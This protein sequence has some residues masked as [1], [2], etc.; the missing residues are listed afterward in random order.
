MLRQ[1]SLINIF[2]N[3]SAAITFFPSFIHAAIECSVA[4][5]RIEVNIKLIKKYLDQD[6][7]NIET[8]QNLNDRTNDIVIENGNFSWGVEKIEE[9]ENQDSTKNTK[10]KNHEKG[11]QVINP[12]E[13]LISFKDNLTNQ[14]HIEIDSKKSKNFKRILKNVNFKARKGELIAVI[15]EIGSGKSSLLQAILNNLLIVDEKEGKK[16]KI[17]LNGSVSYV[18]QSSWIIND[19][20]KNNIL[21]F[22]KN[23]SIEYNKILDLCELRAD[24][25]SLPGGDNTEIG[26]KGINISGG[27][28]ARISIARAINS[29]SDI[30]MFDDP[31]SALDAHVGQKIMKNVIV[32]HLR[33]KTRLLVTH[34]LQYLCF[35]DRIIVMKGGEIFCE[36]DYSS[37]SNEDFFKEFSI[38]VKNEDKSKQ[39]EKKENENENENKSDENKDNKKDRNEEICR[40]TKDEE[41]LEGMVKFG[42]KTKYIKLSGGYKNL[43][44]IITSKFVLI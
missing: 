42:V 7:I 4:L 9:K 44:L 24:L 39:E 38:K 11:N 25:E 33:N 28:K 23:S 5:G 12:E 36:G 3:L 8:S 32:D 31:I 30:Y 21:L 1:I 29:N 16:T 34:A 35:C 19:T 17:S 41:Q 40:I 14:I 2:N 27:Q 18:S 20:I 6:E 22:N 26:E 43:I 13:S 15:G 10:D 37:I